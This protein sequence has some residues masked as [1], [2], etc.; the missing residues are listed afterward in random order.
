MLVILA[1]IILTLDFSDTRITLIG[2]LLSIGSAVLHS[3]YVV[4]MKRPEIES[5]GGAETSLYMTFVGIFV[6]LPLFLIVP[7]TG[8]TFKPTGWLAI[9]GLILISS[10]L[11][12]WSFTMGIKKTKASTAA[13]ICCL[14][15]VVTII[16]ESFFLDGHYSPRQIIGVGLIPAG[17]ILSLQLPKLMKKI[18]LK[19]PSLA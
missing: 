4:N 16:L 5:I 14:E 10:I 11:S 13:T 2:I 19:S 3:F 15:P 1:G 17:I 9:L 12:L 8:F 6:S 7:S 18:K